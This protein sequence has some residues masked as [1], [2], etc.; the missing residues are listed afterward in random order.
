[1][2]QDNSSQAGVRSPLG[3]CEQVSGG[4][5]NPALPG[6]G[7]SCFGL[8]GLRRVPRAGQG[9]ACFEWPQS[10]CLVG[11]ATVRQTRLHAAAAQVSVAPGCHTA[12]LR[13]LHPR[14]GSPGGPLL[15]REWQQLCGAHVGHGVFIACWG[16][17][18]Q[19]GKG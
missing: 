5:P 7:K 4:P 10:F 13:P 9:W 18:L 12:E 15:H 1:M 3:A 14:P 11:S 19:K 16:V 2:L 8:P 6:V 17:G